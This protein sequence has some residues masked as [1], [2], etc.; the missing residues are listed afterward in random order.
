MV[1]EGIADGGTKEGKIRNFLK[2][3]K[4][5]KHSASYVNVKNKNKI[6]IPIT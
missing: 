1:E 5:Y 6:D 4:I 2:E 3:K